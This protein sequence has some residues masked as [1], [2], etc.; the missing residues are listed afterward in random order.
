MS[1]IKWIAMGST[2][3]LFGEVSKMYCHRIINLVFKVS[4]S[5]MWK[6]RNE[7]SSKYLFFVYPRKE[8]NIQCLLIAFH[9]IS[10]VVI[11]LHTVSVLEMKIWIYCTESNSWIYFYIVLNKNWKIYW[12]GESFTGLGPED[13]CSSQGLHYK[14]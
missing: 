4:V 13:Q 12:S 9:I 1:I 14:I 6:P 11:K 2:N 10:Q 7:V 3:L 8:M 5:K